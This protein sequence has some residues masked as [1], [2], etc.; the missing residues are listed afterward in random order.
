MFRN[1]DL[2]RAARRHL[3]RL[4]L[5]VLAYAPALVWAHG[6]TER[7][8]AGAPATAV[9]AAE[10]FEGTIAD[11]VVDDRL[12]QRVLHFPLLRLADGTTVSLA[13]GPLVDR[14]HSG[15]RV[16]VSGRR[17][18]KAVEVTAIESR[19]A[20]AK[21]AEKRDGWH[22]EGVLAVL[23]ADDF[24]HGVGHFRYR[25]N[26]DGGAVTDL[27]LDALPGVL[28]GGMRIEVEGDDAGAGRLAPEHITIV[29]A[30]PE[31]V[32]PDRSVMAKSLTPYKVLVVMANFN[33]TAAP[34]FTAAQA[35]QVMT[36]NAS[37]VTNYYDE[38]SFGTVQLDVTVTSTWL[39][40]AYTAPANCVDG[41]LD[42]FTNAA[43]SAANAAGYNT[44]SYEYLV[45]L[46]PPLPCGWSGLAY[47]SS[48]KQ[49]YINGPGSLVTAVVSHEMGHNFGLL[50]A[51]SLRC[52]GSIGGSCSVAEY[53][54]PFDLMGSS[55]H[56]GH[57]NAMQ[58]SFLQWL[59]PATTPTHNGGTVTYTL[60]PIETGGGATY[61]V[62][63]PTSNSNRTY[64][65][66]YRQPVGFDN[67]T[68]WASNGVQ[69]RVANPFETYCGTCDG[70]NDDTELLDATP[71]TTSFTDAALTVGNSFSDPNY[72]VSV[73][74]LAASAS[75][76]TVQVSTPTVG[77]ATTTALSSSLNPAPTGASVTFT[78]TV[79]GSAPT[80]TVG[81]TEGATTLAGCS[82]IPLAGSGNSRTA[83]CT[84]SS[85]G[86]GTHGITAAYSGD[87]AN[88]ASTSAA[89]SETVNNPGWLGYVG[90][91][92]VASGNSSA[93]AA[94]ANNVA[95]GAGAFVGAGQYN[96]AEGV[97][98]LV[99]GGFDNH[100]TAT[101][102]VVGAGAGNR[103]TGV[104]S[105]VVG[106]GYNLASGN[107]S[108][109]GGGGRQ[110]GSGIAGVAP[111]DNVA[112]GKWSTIL[113]GTGNRAGNTG[114]QTG[115][116]VGGGE[117]NKAL[118]TDAG[119]VGG[120]LNVAS[121]TYASVGGG[122]S[123]TASGSNAHVG[124]GL[125]NTASGVA[126]S[127]PGG[128][129]NV[130]SGNYSFAAGQRAKSVNA[131]AFTFADA[132]AV[133]FASSAN[134]Q[135]SARASGGVRFVTAVDGTGEPVAGVA[136]A[137]G[138]GSWA[139]LSDRNAKT[140]FTPV[141]GAALLA[142]VDVL[143]MYTWRYKSETF[144]AL[145]LG[146]TAQD[147]RAAFGLG[148][149]P[150][151]IADVDASGVALAALKALYE[152]IE[153]R[154][155][156]IQARARQLEALRGRVAHYQDA[157]RE[158][159][160]LLEALRAFT[161]PAHDPYAVVHAIHAITTPEP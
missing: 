61:A 137:A 117:Q 11:L 2:L 22:V 108:F 36:T 57:F 97:S 50:H 100:A 83:A 52:S 56:A 94:G 74:V 112:A 82:T 84:T 28:R 106:G 102:A 67:W 158:L 25:I 71:L 70:W 16:I 8:F 10:Q 78:A 40:L 1:T 121:A 48:P 26:A 62:K 27:A 128:S 58:K 157:A 153:Q 46:F 23:H 124:G 133:D 90:G 75:S 33:N 59:P 131:G 38:A 99:I 149:S 135:F 125:A 86:A 140:D 109:I 113:G 138:S 123:N 5:L 64:W 31:N 21:P 3:G 24:E 103:A 4:C 60:T 37:S 136:L 15:D 18:G 120:T 130:A 142:Q 88:S 89:L 87:G 76:L 115:S 73:Y 39:T 114:T 53:G 42:G 13:A 144:G 104:R 35:L 85:L 145:H 77:G 119:V 161:T 12:E 160:S 19:I 118:N 66:E 54:D 72:P 146:P 92:N 95:S 65:L 51:G 79:A 147:F 14:L 151:R 49:A 141:D 134:N 20:A 96:S 132:S 111:Q 41:D 7:S 127:V 155:K 43:N 156:L 68:G 98:S 129:G 44:A 63:I 69:I 122:Q 32:Q 101:D 91:G 30:A 47:I 110:S 17:N 9:A 148:D 105:V 139:S 152:R 143:P 150:R 116:T 34:S 107:W 126:A 6:D 29:A 154:D 55:S 93:V 81:F 45:Y 159:T 80:G